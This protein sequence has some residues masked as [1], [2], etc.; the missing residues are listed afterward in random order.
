MECERKSPKTC[1]NALKPGPGDDAR[2]ENGMFSQHCVRHCL[3]QFLFGIRAKTEQKS[4]INPWLCPS[5]TCKRGLTV[6]SPNSV[7]TDPQDQRKGKVTSVGVRDP[8]GQNQEF[9]NQISVGHRCHLPL[10]YES[11]QGAWVV[12]QFC[13]SRQNPKTIS[14]FLPVK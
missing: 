5:P 14:F 13:C 11:S 7:K 8:P 10:G 1:V 9:P 12:L 3:L 2:Q 4:A 6:E